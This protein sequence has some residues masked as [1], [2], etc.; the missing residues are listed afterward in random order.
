MT[1]LFNVEGVSAQRTKR[2]F[3]CPNLTTADELPGL[4]A[5]YRMQSPPHRCHNALQSL[6]AGPAR[7]GQ[8]AL[9]IEREMQNEMFDLLEAQ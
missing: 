3:D 7:A 5:K 9:G 1:D 2:C 4:Q 8:T 6:C